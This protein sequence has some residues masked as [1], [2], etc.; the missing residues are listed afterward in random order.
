[1]ALLP[2]LP[3]QLKPEYNYQTIGVSYSYPGA[4]PRTIEEKVTSVIEARLAL[5][6]EVK[7]VRSV[8]GNGYG[9]VTADIDEKADINL[10]SHEVSQIISN[11]YPLLPKGLSYPN[12]Y[13]W[14]NSPGE[15][16]VLIYTA[17]TDKNDEGLATILEDYVIEPLQQVKGVGEVQL[18]EVIQKQI[19]LFQFV[20]SKTKY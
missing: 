20:E 10:A 11:I 16:P 5:V 13:I 12:V 2:K 4:S 7:N 8:S 14:G 18:H 6:R 3:I 9:R 19:N 15:S 1:M 17:L